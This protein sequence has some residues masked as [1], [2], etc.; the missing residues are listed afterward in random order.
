M[1]G[2]GGGGAGGSFP[3]N[4]PASPL[5]LHAVYSVC[6]LAAILTVLPVTTATVERTFSSMKLIKTWLRN[7]M[8][9]ST[10]KH[11]MRICIE[12]PDGLLNETLEVVIARK[13][14]VLNVIWCTACLKKMNLILL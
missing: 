9:E 13:N 10:L 3:S 14:N 2:G 8:G 12:D 4:F 5:M 7:R 11:T 6:I 1:G